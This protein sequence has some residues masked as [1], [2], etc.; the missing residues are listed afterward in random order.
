MFKKRG[1]KWFQNGERWYLMCGDVMGE[2]NGWQLKLS[3]G[4]L[5]QHSNVH[6][7]SY[8]GPFRS[9]KELEEKLDDVE[10]IYTDLC[11]VYF[12]TRNS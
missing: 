6:I 5:R 8:W 3:N 12:P 9:M 7:V 10:N 11:G 1:W 2:F 4:R